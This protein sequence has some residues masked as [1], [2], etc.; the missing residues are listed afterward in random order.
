MAQYAK[1]SQAPQ[2]R[3]RQQQKKAAALANRR[4]K[5]LMLKR[6]LYIIF[7]FLLCVGFINQYSKIININSQINSLE[8]EI[9]QTDNLIDITEG[10][11]LKTINWNEIE[12]TAKNK[13]HMIEPAK[14]DYILIQLKQLPNEY[15]NAQ[16]ETENKKDDAAASRLSTIIDF[17]SK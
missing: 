2:L 3:A 16:S 14:D 17:L 10:K 1:T 11:V 8:K 15:Q 9:K 5:S 12:H 7:V 6:V 4:A 13:L